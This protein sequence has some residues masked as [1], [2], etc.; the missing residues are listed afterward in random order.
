MEFRIESDVLTDAVAWAARVLPPRSPMP[1][2]GGLLLEAAEGR[3]RVSGLDH[4]ASAR[5]EVEADTLAEGRALVLGRRLLDIC[6]VLPRGRTELVVEGARL[7]VTSGDARFGL[8][9][10]PLDDYPAPPALPEVLGTV[11]GDAFAAAVGRIAVAA[12]RDD[13]L[14]VLTGIRLA[15]DGST[16][17]L[18]ATDRYRYAVRT[19]EWY[20]DFGRAAAPATPADV[21]VPARR[22]TEIARSLAGAGPARLALDAGSIGFESGG[23]RTTTR[24]LDGRLPRHDKLFALGDHAL[25][26]TERAPLTEA[27]KRVAVVAEGDSPVQLAFTPSGVHLQAGYEDDVASQH[28]P[29]TLAG[30]DSMTVAFNPGYLLDALSSLDAPE[31]RFHLLG[32]GQRALLTDAEKP[33]HRHLLMSVKP[34]V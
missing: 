29:G 10:L 21:V 8:S 6:K 1:V 9:L 24:L 12:G 34:L 2:L 3:L 14:P 7:T 33:T 23:T 5:V 25:A 22:L 13:S 31:A 15:L 11:D 32:P 26:V 28:L 18:A 19:L 17:T 16:M 30:A 4:E 20:P 27:V